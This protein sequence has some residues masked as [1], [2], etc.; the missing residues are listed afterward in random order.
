MQ[1]YDFSFLIDF[2]Y[3]CLKL[4]KTFLSTVNKQ[5]IIITN[6]FDF[7]SLPLI[8]NPPL[9]R[10]PGNFQL[11]LLLGPLVNLALT[12]NALAAKQIKT[13]HIRKL[14]NFTKWS[15]FGGD[16]V[17]YSVFPPEI[18]LLQSQSNPVQFCL[19]S[20]LRYKYSGSKYS[21]YSCIVDGCK[22]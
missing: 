13:Q 2:S 4:C 11:T 20:L 5:I 3:L 6:F 16:R 18:K 22:L 17:Q 15:K 19:F 7:L 9:L 10:Y 8:K 1:I 21:K 12:S 14:G